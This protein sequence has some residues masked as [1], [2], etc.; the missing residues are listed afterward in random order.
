MTAQ[1]NYFVPVIWSDDPE[2]LADGLKAAD[3]LVDESYYLAANIQRAKA[4]YARAKGVQDSVRSLYYFWQAKRHAHYAVLQAEG[5]QL[6]NLTDAECEE[7]GALL[8][9]RWLWFK[10][11]PKGAL[12]FFGQGLDKTPLAP[13]RKALLLIRS[14]EANHLL[15]HRV[16]DVEGTVRKAL[17]LE[18]YVKLE[19]DK[20]EG[21]RQFLRVLRH[22]M[23]LVWRIGNKAWAKELYEHSIRLSED[24]EH[25]NYIQYLMTQSRWYLLN[26]FRWWHNF[27]PQ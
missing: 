15:R 6:K 10:P 21:M 23:A 1:T 17:S 5:E 25:P 12:I 14:A 9:R 16:Y 24:P 11:D 26:N 3:E 18:E 13:H 2:G 27:L 8:L 20:T 7:I 4:Y 19:D 22:A